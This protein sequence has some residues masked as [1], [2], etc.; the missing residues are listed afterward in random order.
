[1]KSLSKKR[2]FTLIELLV[3]VSIISLLGS[4]VLASLTTARKRANDSARLQTVHQIDNAIQLYITEHGY[5]PTLGGLCG[6]S[7]AENLNGATVFNCVAKS[8][9]VSSQPAYV[10]STAAWNTL[11]SELSKYIPAIKSE[12]CGASC[13]NNLGYVYVAPAAVGFSCL[14][15]GCSALDSSYQ[16]YTTLEQN[17]TQSGFSTI[18]QLGTFYNPTYQQQGGGNDGGGSY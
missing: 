8:N 16:V 6:S 3:V 9:A 7:E 15:Q 17:R 2:G 11:K 1:M 10:Q 18:S 12:N 4:V 13:P 5:A 14:N